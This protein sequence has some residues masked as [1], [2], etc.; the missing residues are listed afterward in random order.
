MDTSPKEVS[1][2]HISTWKYVQYIQYIQ[3]L[4]IRKMLIR[5][6]MRYHYITVRMTKI[7]KTGHIKYWQDVGELELLTYWR[8]EY[9]MVQ[10]LGKTDWQF[11]KLL[12]IHLPYNPTFPLLGI[13]PKE[14]K[15]RV[16]AQTCAWMF[17]AALN[18][19]V[20]QTGNNP[21][22]YQRFLFRRCFVN[23]TFSNPAN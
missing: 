6:I 10:P 13:C 1:G 2:W 15:A 4:V 23:E 12:N 17:M 19:I 20:T 9:K 21:D 3:S 16:H 7:E 11:P 22:V 8:W 18:V 5:T 14:M